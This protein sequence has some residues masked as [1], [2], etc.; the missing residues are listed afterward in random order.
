M[1]A[2]TWQWVFSVNLK[3]FAT[4]ETMFRWGRKHYLVH[5]NVRHMFLDRYTMQVYG[6]DLSMCAPMS[7]EM[8]ATTKE[9]EHITS[10]WDHHPNQKILQLVDSKKTLLQDQYMVLPFLNPSILYRRDKK[11]WLISW[12]SDP[13]TFRVVR[14]DEFNHTSSSINMKDS[15]SWLT[16]KAKEL[17]AEHCPYPFID[18]KGED[19]RLFIMSS[20][21]VY[22]AYAR[23]YPR[24]IPEIRMSYVELFIT[25]TS[26]TIDDIVDITLNDESEKMHDQKNWS[27]FEYN[28][29]LHFIGLIW[30]HRIIAVDIDPK[31]TWVGSGKIVANSN[32]DSSTFSW[33]YGQLRGGTPAIRI[34][35]DLFLTF[36]HSSID[37]PPVG[38]VLKTYVMGAYTFRADGQFKIVAISPEPI[39]EETMYN[40]KW[41]ANLSLT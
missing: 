23:R 18:I 25:K 12:R 15:V 16:D 19:P 4:N 14:I 40:G 24:R 33:S 30:P 5:E 41:S 39:V 29:K 28:N 36:F 34:Q 11:D 2:L 26:I 27:P 8:F 31:H 22:A 9:G 17:S 32:M 13:N 21:Q 10:V 35:E 1:Y 38:D 20:G 37:P 3:Q 7:N 6:F